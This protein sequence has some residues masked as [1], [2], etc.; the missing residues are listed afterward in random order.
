MAGCAAKWLLCSR[1]VY[2]SNCKDAPTHVI[3]VLEM[4]DADPSSRITYVI[5]G[6][7]AN[8]GHD[9]A[10]SWLELENKKT[11]CGFSAGW[12]HFISKKIHDC[13]CVQE[14]AQVSMPWIHWEGSSVKLALELC[15]SLWLPAVS[16]SIGSSTAVVG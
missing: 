6:T 4:R 1:L 3:F 9:V 14:V 8:L 15:H 12:Y 13:V 16:C 2:R 10:N 7:L 11:C 5:S